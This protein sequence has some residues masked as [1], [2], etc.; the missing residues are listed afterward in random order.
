[1]DEV[2]TLETVEAISK[3][4][5]DLNWVVTVGKNI[6]KGLVGDEVETGEDLLLL[7][8]I[9]VKSFLAELDLGEEDSSKS[10]VTSRK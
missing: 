7:L 10:M 4:L 3:I 9:L 1:L 2:K 5:V 6:K 8:E